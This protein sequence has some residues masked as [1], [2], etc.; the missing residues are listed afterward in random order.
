LGSLILGAAGAFLATNMKRFVAYTAINQMGFLFIGLSALSVDGMKSTITYLYIYMLANVLFFCVMTLLQAKKYILGDASLRS[1]NDVVLIKT[2]PIEMSLLA[3]SLLS[4]GGLPPLAGFAGKYLL[5]SS[6]ISQYLQTGSFGIAE[7][8][9]YILVVSVVLSLL[10]TF[11]Y[12]RLIKM[13]LFDAFNGTS[14]TA[15][16]DIN[17]VSNTL[18]VTFILTMLGLI[19]AG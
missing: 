15:I 1:L 11:Y 2:A 13:A 4:L 3:V 18:M 8:L 12:L 9:L 19:T 14:G 10:S 17:G 16:V 6:L 5:W 7:N